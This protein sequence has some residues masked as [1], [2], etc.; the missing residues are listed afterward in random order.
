MFILLKKEVKDNS[1]A[2]QRLLY[3][4]DTSSFELPQ[5]AWRFGDVQDVQTYIN[6]EGSQEHLTGAC[7]PFF[8]EGS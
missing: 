8:K 5:A 1:W 4:F 3:H 6:P 2:T 7:L